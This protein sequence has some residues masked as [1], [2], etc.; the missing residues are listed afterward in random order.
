MLRFPPTQSKGTHIVPMRNS[1]KH[2]LER[3]KSSERKYKKA[4]TRTSHEHD[5]HRV[6][7]I[8]TESPSDSFPRAG[9]VRKGSVSRFLDNTPH[10]HKP[11]FQ[12]LRPPGMETKEICVL[13]LAIPK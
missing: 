3:K 11:E 12:V 13:Q 7:I 10:L 8:L 5:L 6:V 2:F 1:P 4:K 9:G